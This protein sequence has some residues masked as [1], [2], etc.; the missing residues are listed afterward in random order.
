MKKFNDK[1]IPSGKLIPRVMNEDD[2]KITTL[3]HPQK[4]KGFETRLKGRPVDY[5]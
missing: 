2:Y 1:G 3:P 5:Q 4:P